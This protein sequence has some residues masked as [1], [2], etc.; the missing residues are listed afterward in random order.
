RKFL[1][2]LDLREKEMEF[3]LNLSQDLKPPKYPPIQQQKFKPKNIPLIFQKHSTPT[4]SPFQTPPYH[5]P[6]HL[7]YLPP[8]RSQIPKKHSA[9]HTPPLLPPMYHPIQYPP[10]SQRLLHDFPKYSP[11][12]LSNPLT[13]Q[14]HPTQLLPH[15]L[16]PKQLFKK[17]YNQINFTYL[18]HPPN[19][20]PNPLIQPPPIIPITFHLLSPKQLNPTHQLLNPSNNIPHKNPPKILL[21]HHI[22]QP[23]KPSHLIYTHLSLSIPQPHQLSQKPIKLL[24]PYPLTKQLIKKTPNPHTIFQHSLPSFHHTQT[25]IPKHIQHNYPLNQI[26]LT[27]QLFQTQQSLLFQHPHNTPHT[28]KPVMVAT[29]GE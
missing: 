14:H 26:Q 24:Q 5:Q 11:L 2:L 21:T 16:T 1:R 4:P 17:P 15:F 25:K 27:N 13:H 23:L 6:P 9:K 3:L 28:I 12:P 20:L 29:L 18:P 7:T 22:H 10:F 19:N 8:T